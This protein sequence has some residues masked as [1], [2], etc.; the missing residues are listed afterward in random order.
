MA[1]SLLTR[2]QAGAEELLE[3]VGALAEIRR[4]VVAHCEAHPPAP[5]Y[6][7]QEIK[8]RLVPFGWK[9]E[10]RVP[11]YAPAWDHLRG[12]ERYDLCKRFELDGESV[13]VAIEIERWEIQNDLLKF[14]RGHHRGIIAA[15]VLLH[16]GPTNLAYC[17]EHLRHVSE[18]L[19]GHLPI[20]F[21]APTG[22]GLP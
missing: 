6:K 12:N 15:G 16:D 13:G 22:P 20:L 4:A 11:T 2:S 9:P 18:P 19:F 8:R 3:R 21:C 14:R 17:F 5:P 10:M 7:P 1:Y